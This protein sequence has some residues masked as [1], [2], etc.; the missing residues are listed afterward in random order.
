MR[1]PQAL[2]QDV[3]DTVASTLYHD[4]GSRGYID[5][6]NV[7]ATGS[8]NWLNRNEGNLAT[9]GNLTVYGNWVQGNSNEGTNEYGDNV[10]N[11][12]PWNGDFSALP[13]QYKDYCNYAGIPPSQR[14]SRPAQSYPVSGP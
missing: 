3:D 6:D 8:G 12:T 2:V 10:Y 4:E 13:Q 7:C 1:A 14:S 11:N 5:F 9:T